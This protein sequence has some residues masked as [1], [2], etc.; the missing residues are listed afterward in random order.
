[1]LSDAQAVARLRKIL[2]AIPA[3]HG[4]GVKAWAERHGLHYSQV[5]DVRDGRRAMNER[6]AAAIGL[7]RVKG[8]EEK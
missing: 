7:K 1:M 2:A 3:E 8:W 5:R 6:V 4:G